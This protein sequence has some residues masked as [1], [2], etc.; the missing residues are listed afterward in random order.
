LRNKRLRAAPA[1]AGVNDK[2]LCGGFSSAN[3]SALYLLHD[4]CMFPVSVDVKARQGVPA[5]MRDLV[6]D[7]TLEESGEAEL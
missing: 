4:H 7:K 5:S 1:T 2:L 6:V 3:P